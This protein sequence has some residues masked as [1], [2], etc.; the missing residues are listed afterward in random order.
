MEEERCG[1]GE[2]GR[3]G[4]GEEWRRAGVEEGRSGR[5]AAWR[6]RGVEEGRRHGCAPVLLLLARRRLQRERASGVERRRLGALLGAARDGGRLLPRVLRGR[7]G[8]S[9]G[10]A[11]DM[12][13]H[14]HTRDMCMCMCMCL[15]VCVCLCM[16][17]CMSCVLHL[18]RALRRTAEPRQKLGRSSAEARQ[19]L[20]RSSISAHLDLSPLLHISL[21]RRISDGGVPRT[22]G[23]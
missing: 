18:P 10:R 4:G 14:M 17:M 12:H 2:E 15:C 1:R 19:K 7:A 16:C 13:M 23:R 8:T 21:F 5:G 22:G 11:G 6:R 3:S 20:G 9:H